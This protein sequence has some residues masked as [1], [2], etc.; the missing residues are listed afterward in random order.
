MDDRTLILQQL[1]LS[2]RLLKH[3]LNDITDEDAQRIP[4][5]AV[6]PIIWH[7]G[8]VALVNFSFAGGRDAVRAK[9]PETYPGLFATGTGGKA[10]YPVFGTVVKALDDSGAALA[11]TVADADLST[12]AEGPFDAWHNH[13]EMFAFS[14]NHRWYHIG[15][16]TTLRALLGKPRL[17]G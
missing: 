14:N 13:A 17:F 12:P 9:L 3:T 15:K 2:H 10:D 8:H 5:A 11:A 6:S 1:A 4:S 7:V 16:I